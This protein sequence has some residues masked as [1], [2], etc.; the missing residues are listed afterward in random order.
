MLAM[1]LLQAMD[2][3]ERIKPKEPR[4]EP[5][6]A[7]LPDLP[8]DVPGDDNVI[9]DSLKGVV[10]LKIDDKVA[11]Q[12]DATGVDSS[13]IPLLNTDA[14]RQ[15][16]GYFIGKPISMKRLNQ[17]VRLT[18]LHHRGKDRPLVDVIVPE[19]DIT[20]GVVQLVVIE[21]KVGQVKIEG[22]E[23]FRDELISRRIRTKAGDTVYASKIR[24]ELESI[25]QNPFRDVNV[26]FTPGVDKGLTDVIYQVEDRFPIRFYA[27]YEDTGNQILGEDR[28]LYGFNWGNAFQQ[29][30]EMGYQFTTSIGI[31]RYRGH[32]GYFRA[33]IPWAEH[34]VSLFGSH[35][36]VDAPINQFFDEEGTTWQIGFRYMAPLPSIN[37]YKHYIQ[38]G[39]DFKRSD[40]N[41]IFGGVNIFHPVTDVT[42]FSLEYGGSAKDK[43]GTTSFAITGTASP[44]KMTN[45]QRPE[46][47]RQARFN[48]D[49]EYI[50]GTLVVSRLWDLPEGITALT[51]FTGQLASQNLLG[52]EQLG[53]GGYSTI[54]GYYE[55]EYNADQ[56]FMTTVELRSPRWMV[57]K[58]G[59]IDELASYFQFIGFWDYGFGRNVELGPI[60]SGHDFSGV[61][62]GARY[63]M[64]TH[65]AIRFDYAWRLEK[66]YEKNDGGKMHLGV[67]VSY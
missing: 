62:L 26:L 36:S 58:V 34:Q 66:G 59:D 46:V 21:G 60:E 24:R 6:E 42:Q 10:L 38:G 7:R 31:E 18:I 64:G 4:K 65:I 63:N 19:Q 33:P 49:P 17:I 29:D 55:R 15:K 1:P 35:A 43:F 14:Y 47:Y 57:G 9:V 67:V 56:G 54:R 28:Q 52:S 23:W 32:S 39:F 13:R 5:V 44:F 41:L 12:A 11:E 3:Y 2:E 48:S 50:Y 8:E 30:M 53:F 27:G 61:G 22:N 16:I 45:N 51:K 40:T 25:N 20:N 37:D